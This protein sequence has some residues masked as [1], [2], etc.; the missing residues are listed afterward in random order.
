MKIKES[1]ISDNKSVL[2]I[3]LADFTSDSRVHLIASKFMQPNN[4]RMFVDLMMMNRSYV[5][6]SDYFFAQWSNFYLSDRVLS[7]EFRYVFDRT[8]A[9]RMLG[10]TLDRP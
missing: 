7:D 4:S 5:N 3:K 8:H 9:A 2:R 6:C 10:N 1:E